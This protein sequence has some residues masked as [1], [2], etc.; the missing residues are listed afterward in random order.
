MTDR[1]LTI[2][3]QGN[4]LGAVG[5][6]EQHQPSVRIGL[7]DKRVL[8]ASSFGNYGHALMLAQIKQTKRVNDA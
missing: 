8:G 5:P 2:I 6:H 7:D 4:V 1:L 3:E